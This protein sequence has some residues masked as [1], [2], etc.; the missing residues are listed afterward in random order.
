M[1][2]FAMQPLNAL[3][4]F[5][6]VQLCAGGPQATKQKGLGVPAKKNKQKTNGQLY[7]RVCCNMYEFRAVT[8]ANTDTQIS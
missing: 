4:Q 6:R 3:F 1:S 8:N 5:P 7:T 2:E